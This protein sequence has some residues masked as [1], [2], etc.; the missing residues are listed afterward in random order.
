MSWYRSE[1]SCRSRAEEEAAEKERRSPPT[2]HSTR[3]D[4]LDTA[5]DEEPESDPAELVAV[6]AR[7]RVR[8]RYVPLNAV[9][10]E[11]PVA[12]VRETEGLTLILPRREADANGVKYDGLYKMITL[13]VHSSLEAVGE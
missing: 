13:E 10:G 7:W 11:K 5:N 12:A 8:L 6:S 2:S 9:W 4:R 3:V 1:T